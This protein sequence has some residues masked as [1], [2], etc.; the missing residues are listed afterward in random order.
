MI[1]P[2]Q[3]I[4]LI[5]ELRRAGITDT[6][7]LSAFEKVPRDL[8]V[9]DAFLDQ[10][11]EDTPLPIGHGQTISQ[12]TVVAR[13]IHALRPGP[14]LKVLEVGCGSGYGTA[15]L[16]HLFRRV[17]TIERR[18]PLF[19]AALQRVDA[20]RRYNVTG[21]PGDGSGGWPEQAPFDRILV[22]AAAGDIPSR[23]WQQLAPG[24]IM[25]CP[26]GKSP[27]RQRLLRIER[28]GADPTVEDL[29]PARFV[30]LV[31]DRAQTTL[32]RAG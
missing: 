21:R 2:T 30:P 29:G 27:G 20:L 11:W 24:G 7:I 5:L 9:P 13:M 18:R 10:A 1:S 14:T 8:F 3:K 19:A 22:A 15:V 32:K 16:S 4:R 26:V 28:H 12:P 25:V 23:L 31:D 6:G 17:Y